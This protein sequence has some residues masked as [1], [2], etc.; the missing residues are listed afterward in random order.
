MKKKVLRTLYWMIKRFALLA[1]AVAMGC[2]AA[3]QDVRTAADAWHFKRVVYDGITNDL[4][5]AGLGTKGLKSQEE[6]TLAD[7]LAPTA[8]ELRR[9]AIYKNYRALVDCTTGGG[10]GVLY[11][12]NVDVNGNPTDSQGL[13]SGAEYLTFANKWGCGGEK[14]TLMVQ[15]PDTFDPADA[16]VVTA[17][18]SGSRGIYGAI[19]TAGE[20]GLKHGCAVAYTCAGKGIGVHDLQN[21]TVNLID[22][23]REDAL[24]AG[25]D[26]NFTA[27][28]G[29]HGLAAYNAAYP[30]RFAFTHAHSKHNPEASWDDNVLQSIR[31]AFYVINHELKL[32]GNHHAEVRPANT[33]VIA[34]NVSN[35]GGASLRAAEKDY[36]SL[37]DGVAVGEPNVTPRRL[38]PKRDFIIMQGSRP[39]VTKHSRPLYDYISL[40]QVYQGCAN[41]AA[42][43]AAAPWNYT[44][45][46]LGRNNCTSLKEKGLLTAETVEAQADEALAII[47]A[48]G[49]LPEQ[50][51]LQ[52][53][54]YYFF[55]PESIAVTYANAYSRSGVE[56]N[57]AG[58]SFGATTGNPFNAKPADAEAGWP[59][60]LDAANV[61]RLFGTANGIPPTAGIHL[62]NNMS[63]EKGSPRESRIS[64]SSSTGRQDMNVDGAL[65]LRSLWTGSDAATG[66]RLRGA[67]RRAYLKLHV[68]VGQILSSGDLHGKPAIIVTG[69]NDAVLAINHASRSYFGLNQTVEGRRSNLRYYEVTNAHHLDAFN[70]LE[71]F[72]ERMIPLHY[73]FTKAMDMMYTHLKANAP[74]A[75]SQV[76]RTIPRG[77]MNDKVP[78]IS[79]DNVP[80]IQSDPGG[81]AI[82]F[83]DRT[84]MIPELPSRKQIRKNLIK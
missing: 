1:A 15:I 34:S 63:A 57:L 73:Y 11:G 62:I 64:T 14:V 25:C 46:T 13:I 40:L 75:P 28:L 21:N 20:W 76:V 12:P 23:L 2:G 71:G 77:R 38:S 83:Q 45:R 24:E 32:R 37:I 59:K 69:R 3:T 8:D 10:F 6:P 56:E 36:Y 5:T 51:I 50:N 9:L 53:A 7:P 61:N 55:V 74:L 4:L 31:F 68:G 44:N 66:E 33:I 70:S 67:M 78:P 26:S 16:C 29:P 22:G 54:L 80:D 81:D 18:S 30:H 65:K 41:L 72:N 47:N 42:A 84:V 43:N 58:Y 17:P 35:G 82:V 52:P 49:I 60:A 19:G 39:P 48:Y 27:D 79:K